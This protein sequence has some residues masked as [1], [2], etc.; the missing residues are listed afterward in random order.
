MAFGPANLPRQTVGAQARDM[1][2]EQVRVA[3][4]DVRVQVEALDTPI[5][6]TV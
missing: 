1:I 2:S 5:F 6:I 3:V 4:Q